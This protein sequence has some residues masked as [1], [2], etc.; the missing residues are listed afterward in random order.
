ML[1]HRH[2]TFCYNYIA[3]VVIRHGIYLKNIIP[4]VVLRHGQYFFNLPILSVNK[5]RTESPFLP[6]KLSIVVI[7]HGLS[8]Y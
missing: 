4:I 8:C 3:I 6:L 1:G 5:T 7:Q 2:A